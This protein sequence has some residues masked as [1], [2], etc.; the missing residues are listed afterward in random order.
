[1]VLTHMGNALDEARLRAELPPGVEP[2]FDG[3]VLEVPIST[4][5]RVDGS[6]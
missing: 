3:Q 4:A 5:R 1:M 6:P 2:G